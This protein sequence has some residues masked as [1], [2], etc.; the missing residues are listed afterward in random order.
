MLL[1]FRGY[2]LP[3][4][5]GLKCVDWYLFMAFCFENQWGKGY[6]EWELVS[7]LGLWTRKVMRIALLRAQ[8]CVKNPIGS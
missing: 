4:S 6:V 8:E 1:T 3:P 5:S 2:M 7:H